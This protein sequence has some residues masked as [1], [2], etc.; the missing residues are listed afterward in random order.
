M[1][2]VLGITPS[3]QILP[4]DGYFLGIRYHGYD[5]KA[6]SFIGVGSAG[7]LVVALEP[8]SQRSG[9]S[10]AECPFVGGL[11]WLNEKHI[12]R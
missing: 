10:Y 7:V 3:G 2:A 5:V 6:G 1:F 9:S 8:P 4:L 11:K 12:Y